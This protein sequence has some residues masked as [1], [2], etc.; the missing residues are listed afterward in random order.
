MDKKEVLEEIK[1]RY[2]EALGK[3]TKS[4]DC[5][6]SKEGQVISIEINK[7]EYS[8]TRQSLAD[9]P[10]GFGDRLGNEIWHWIQP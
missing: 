10:E 6:I 2:D 9:K 4:F 8:V 3:N 5:G 1:K 7:K